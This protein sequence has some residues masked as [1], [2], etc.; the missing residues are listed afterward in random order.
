MT[1]E[2]KP[3]SA[4][5]IEGQRAELKRERIRES[6]KKTKA[7]GCTCAGGGGTHKARADLSEYAWIWKK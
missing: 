7:D 5:G 3:S 6:T 1:G 2:T 4:S